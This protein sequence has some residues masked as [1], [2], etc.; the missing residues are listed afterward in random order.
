[1]NEDATRRSSVSDQ[2]KPAPIDF[3]PVPSPS[4]A[5]SQA[6]SSKAP[7]AEDP[8]PKAGTKSGR[9]DSG[10]APTT[11]RGF[12]HVKSPALR[13]STP[14][15]APPAMRPDSDKRAAPGDAMQRSDSLPSQSSDDAYVRMAAP[16][17][18][19]Q[20]TDS[21]LSQSS[22]GVTPGPAKFSAAE[23]QF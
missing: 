6:S 12:G 22:D 5:S 11:G 4:H 14:A 7:A 9:D 19:V 18:T 1:A 15:E 13:K 2:P 17:D 3:R 10:K 20:R 21:L 16:D 23:F 8:Y